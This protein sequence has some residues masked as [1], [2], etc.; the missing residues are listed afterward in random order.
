MTL[1]VL[2]H[3]A[4]ELPDPGQMSF[5]PLMGALGLFVGGLVAHLRGASDEARARWTSRGTW[6]GIGVGLAVWL[7][8]FAI[9]PL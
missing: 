2:V 7:L 8:G 9:H 6:W 1:G 4:S 3:L 5:A